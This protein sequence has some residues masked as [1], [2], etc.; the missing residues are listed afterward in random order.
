MS[1]V[2]SL[3]CVCACVCMCVCVHVHVCV[4]TA[5]SNQAAQCPQTSHRN[6]NPLTWHLN[7][8][9]TPLHTAAQFNCWKIMNT[10]LTSILKSSTSVII[11]LIAIAEFEECAVTEQSCFTVN[12]GAQHE[13][14]AEDKSCQYCLYNPISKD[15]ASRSGFRVCTAYDTAHP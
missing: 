13:Q 11:Q 2:T 8:H 5:A 9:H 10:I 7:Q 6:L 12:T 1:A 4:L 15:F 3:P 14:P